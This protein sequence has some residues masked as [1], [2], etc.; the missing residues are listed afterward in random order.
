MYIGVKATLY[1][2]LRVGALW[3]TVCETVTY[4]GTSTPK[5]KVLFIFSSKMIQCL[6]DFHL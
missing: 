3:K 6:I 1:T 5:G 2:M 4:P